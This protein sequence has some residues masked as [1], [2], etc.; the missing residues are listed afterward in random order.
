[1]RGVTIRRDA[2]QLTFYLN[3]FSCDPTFRFW[4]EL[5][6]SRRSTMTYIRD[7]FHGEICGTTH[8]QASY[9]GDNNY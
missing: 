9:Q 2:L 8:A 5:V 7:T 3:H 4:G 6:R 1:M